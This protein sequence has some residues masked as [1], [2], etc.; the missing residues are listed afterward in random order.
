MSEEYVIGEK[1]GPVYHITLNRPEKRNA[2][3]F[4]MMI[5][6][7]EMVEEL[8]TDPEVRVIILKGAGPVYS[9]AAVCFP[10]ETGEKT[11]HKCGTRS[12]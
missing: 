12:K 10:A 5:R 11:L 7:S 3:L 1:K 4:D 8:I 9:A 6:L 2:I